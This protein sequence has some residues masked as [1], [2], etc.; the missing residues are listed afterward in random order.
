MRSFVSVKATNPA[1]AVRNEAHPLRGSKDDYDKLLD[2]IGDS[3]VVLLGEA[4]HGTHEFYQQRADITRRLIQ[5]KGFSVIAIE[6]DWPDALMINNYVKGSSSDEAMESLN[7]FKRFPTWM[8]R[9]TVVLEFI[10]WLRTYNQQRT[11][12]NKVGFFGLDLYSLYTSIDATI[13]YLDKIDP[14]AAQR[15]RYR[16]GCFEMFGEDSQAYGYAASFGL[17]KPCKEQ[18]VNQLIDLHKHALQY[19]SMD[20]RGALDDYFYAEQNARV[21]HN[22][23][24]YYRSMFGSRVSSWN[25]RDKHM[26]E[27]L[28]ALEEHYERAGQRFKAVVWAHNSH[29]GDAR[30][31][32]MG[33]AGELNVGQLVRERYHGKCFLVG[34]STNRGTVTAASN[35][36]AAAERKNVRPGLPNS[37]EALFHEVGEPIDMKNF[38]VFLRRDSNAVEVLR[39]ERLQ[40]AIGV[41]Y[42]PKT[43]RLSH[44]FMARLSDQF[45]ALLHFDETRAL[46]PLEKNS[47][48]NS[49]EMPETYPTGI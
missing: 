26:V 14:E 27:T 46:E 31:T 3:Q 44:Y 4:S 13:E 39:Q 22:A 48:W 29:L 2:S 37:Y 36:G 30:A 7:G 43:E 34:F 11:N 33:E 15:A 32:Q 47:E 42:L 49:G 12:N 35:W 38:M 25:L 17:S 20:G 24:R 5:E 28:V 8:W 21:V 9:N 18:V 16:Y 45:D 23:E 10:Q 40:R 19:E 1:D 41:I 6:G